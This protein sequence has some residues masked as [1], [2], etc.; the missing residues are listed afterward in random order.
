MT[1]SDPLWLDEIPRRF[2]S[3]LESVVGESSLCDDGTKMSVLMSSSSSFSMV[4]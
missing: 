4:Y 3:F 2:M 1:V